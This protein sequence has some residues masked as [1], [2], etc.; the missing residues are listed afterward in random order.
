MPSASLRF[1]AREEEA[2]PA[3]PSPPA[4]LTMR[5]FPIFKSSNILRLAFLAA[6]GTHGL[7]NVAA[8]GAGVGLGALAADRQA[9]AVAQTAVGADVFE[10]L[11]VAR[12]LALEVALELKALQLFADGVFLIGG[13][14]IGLFHQIN[15]CRGQNFGRA[16]GADTVQSRQCIDGAFVRNCYTGDTHTFKYLNF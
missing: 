8:D 3:A 7:P 2:A 12:H 11:D 6:A 13:Q 14:L 16:S 15:F 5:F 10:A 9:L 1:P 4:F